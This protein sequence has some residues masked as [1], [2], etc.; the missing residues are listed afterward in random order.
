YNPPYSFNFFQVPF[1]IINGAISNTNSPATPT[2]VDLSTFASNPDVTVVSAK[3][4]NLRSSYVE[5]ANLALQREIGA[6]TFTVAWVGEFGRALLRTV[7]LDQN[8]SPG[9]NYVYAAQLP[10][11]NTITQAYNGAMSSYNAMQLVYNRRF[12]RGLVVNANYTWAHNLSNNGANNGNAGST[13]VKDPS[14]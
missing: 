2:P 13:L 10:N 6:N 4:L 7:N 3:P 14:I 9:S 8:D 5:M 11:V 12:T 1:W